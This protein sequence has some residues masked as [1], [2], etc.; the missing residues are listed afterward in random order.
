[1][2][3]SSR[4]GNMQLTCGQCKRIVEY[5]GDRPSFCAYC[6]QALDK[7]KT[8]PAPLRSEEAVTLVG[9]KS[10]GETAP[11][12]MEVAGYRLLKE[13]GSGGMGAVY[14]AEEVASGR[15]V[16]LKLISPEFVR[17]PDA[18]ER[19]RQEGRIASMVAH[20]RCVFVLAVDE[21]A[22]R[23][24]IVMERMPG[25]TLKDLVDKEG[26]LP[27]ERA[28]ALIHDVIEGLQEAHRMEVIHRDVKPSNCF[29]EADGRVKVG[30]FG[31]AKSLVKDAH[32]TR[33]GAFVGTPH[34]ASPEQ[35]RGEAIDGRTDV[36]STAATLYYLLTGNPPYHGSDSG[37]A[38]AR[39]LTDPPPRLRRFR[40]DVA[41]ALE[42]VILRGLERD[43]ERRWSDLEA[44]RQALVTLAPPPLQAGDQSVRLLAYVSDHV[45]LR[46]AGAA[47]LLLLGDL[48]GQVI[49]AVLFLLYFVLLEGLSGAS[50]GKRLL[51]LRVCALA[52]ADL[53]SLP[54]ILGRT[55]L[56]FLL[57][58]G[59][60]LAAALFRPLAGR[61]FAGSAALTYLFPWGW[62]LIGTALVVSTMQRI[63]G[64]RGLHELTSGTRVVRRAEEEGRRLNPASGSWLVSFLL[65]RRLERGAGQ[66]AGL[67]ERIAGFAIR[68][69]LKWTDQDKVLLGEDPSLGRRVFVWLRPSSAAPLSPARR[70]V[71]RRTR[72][73]W[74]AS[75]NQG[76]LQWDALLAPSGCPLT[77]FV[78]SE[79][80]FAWRE[81]RALL[82]ELAGELAAACADGTLPPSLVPGQVW[83]HADGRVQLADSPLRSDD[84]ASEHLPGDEARALA[85]LRQTA[86]L[87]LE[88]KPRG[89]HET[90]PIQANLSDVAR[91]FLERLA[92]DRQGFSTVQ[93][94]L[95]GL[96][97]L[98]DR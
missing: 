58:N 95:A 46:L 63:N 64:Y 81:A 68:G 31:L 32:L 74:L 7:E 86:G 69:A 57:V 8:T 85:L 93:E 75:G 13:L 45:L 26:P 19:F 25:A 17:S 28:I 6:G 72:L 9:P 2:N 4:V 89:P 24:Y 51:R 53:P 48:I 71:G 44:F 43:R 84:A 62:L 42:R 59:G 73:R 61:E 38:L 90:R 60:F 12:P 87:V 36:Y 18:V 96:N 83:I 52:S 41:P 22:G 78:Q 1:L 67:P 76:D 40:P 82:R 35:V 92:A 39:I 21:E 29:L 30:D 3:V 98:L 49:F 77:D 50:L 65:S 66:A 56:F 11:M 14:D 15:R 91:P 20:P 47:A 16:A 5:S 70:D 79:G 54:R 80:S 10:S 97:A 88:G 55:M 34:F 27:A 37:A 94:V 23:P 33:T